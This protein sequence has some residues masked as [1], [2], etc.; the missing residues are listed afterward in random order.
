MTHTK[1]ENKYVPPKRKEHKK[2]RIS[3]KSIF[4]KFFPTGR[5]KMEKS[6]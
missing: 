5:S 2:T 6:K 1:M 4:G 3:N